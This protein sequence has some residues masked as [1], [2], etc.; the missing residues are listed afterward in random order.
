MGIDPVRS[1]LST[2]YVRT[3]ISIKAHQLSR[4]PEFRASDRPDIEQD[5]AAQVLRKA[6]L[7]DPARSCPKTFITRVV[8]TAAAMLVR[9]RGRIKRAAGNKAVS[10]EG[11][12]LDVNGHTCMGE[13]MGEADR[14][15]R[16]QRQPQTDEELAGLRSDVAEALDE[17]PD[18]LQ[19]IAALLV[20]HTEA[21]IA[22]LLGISRRQV[23]NAVELIR[24]HFE[25]AG[26][27]EL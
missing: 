16:L 21:G 4:R 1:A 25:Q 22:R 8:E 10:L 19:P 13:L 17:L 12:L 26:L 14:Q 20:E 7:Y 24:E 15:R 9:Q 27:G 23:R 18:D 6:H 3:L 5:L 2:E 11:T